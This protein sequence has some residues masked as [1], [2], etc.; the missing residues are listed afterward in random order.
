M[1]L[2]RHAVLFERLLRLVIPTA[3]CSCT[4]VVSGTSEVRV[5]EMRAS[6]CDHACVA[7]AWLANAL[8]CGELQFVFECV[9]MLAG[10]GHV[11]HASAL[12]IFVQACEEHSSA[13]SSG[14]SAVNDEVLVCWM[15]Q[16][17]L[18]LHVDRVSRL[19]LAGCPHRG[20]R[21]VHLV[22]PRVVVEAVLVCSVGMMSL[23]DRTCRRT[24]NIPHR[25]ANGCRRSRR[26]MRMR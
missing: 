17:C 20:P 18:S 25:A 1:V 21:L 8:R 24:V 10:R 22:L 15:S 6:L 26:N 4:A 11:L 19:A 9:R 12:A 3:E 16:V 2:V 23:E 7:H 14:G 13:G 5:L